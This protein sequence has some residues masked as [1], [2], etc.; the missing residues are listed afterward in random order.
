[1]EEII[2]EEETR[3]EGLDD[4]DSQFILMFIPRN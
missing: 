3:K 2:E 4:L 1:M